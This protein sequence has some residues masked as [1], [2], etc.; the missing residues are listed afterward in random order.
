[1]TGGDYRMSVVFTP[2]DPCCLSIFALEARAEPQLPQPFRRLHAGADDPHLSDA[3][4]SD[5][6][7]DLIHSDKAAQ[8]HRFDRR[9]RLLPAGFRGDAGPIWR[10]GSTGRA[11]LPFIAATATRS[12]QPGV[13]GELTLGNMQTMTEESPIPMP[14]EDALPPLGH[15]FVAIMRRRAL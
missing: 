11:V 14:T 15:G 9:T 13:L 8:V 6:G 10:I 7:P 4:D 2:A 3:D 5:N 1:M 12:R